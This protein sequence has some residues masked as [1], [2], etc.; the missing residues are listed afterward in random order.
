M[1]NRN[2]LVMLAMGAI[3]M[4][5]IGGNAHAVL[6]DDFNGGDVIVP[7]PNTGKTIIQKPYANAIGGWR[8]MQFVYRDARDSLAV[9]GGVLTH[10]EDSQGG[11]TGSKVIWHGPPSTNLIYPPVDLTDGGSS[12]RFRLDITAVEERSCLPT[13]EVSVF[14]EN[15]DQTNA[16]IIPDRPGPYDILFTDFKAL[17][18]VFAGFDAVLR[19]QLMISGCR[20]TSPTVV[21][22]IETVEPPQGN[23]APR[24]DANGPYTGK[25]EH[26]VNFDGSG[27]SDP[28]GTIV[29][30]DWDF[31]D[32]SSGSGANTTHVYEVGGV[33]HVTL[34]VTDDSNL[35]TSATTTAIIGAT[36][37]PPVADANG[38]YTGTRGVDV[39][40]DGSGSSDPDGTIMNYEWDF[41]DS[42]VGRGVNPSHTYTESNIYNVTLTVSDDTGEIDQTVTTATIAE[43]NQPP[44]VDLNGPYTGTVGEVITFDGSGSSDPD[45]TIVSYEWD[46]GDGNVGSGVSP[47]HSYAVDDFYH[48]TLTVTDDS[49]SSNSAT[50]LAGINSEPGECGAPLYDTSVDQAIF[51]WQDCATGDWVVRLSAGSGYTQYT[52]SIIGAPFSIT[53]EFRLEAGDILSVG[54]RAIVFDMRVISPWEDGFSFM[55][56]ADSGACFDMSAT[57]SSSVFV[58][59]S[60]TPATVPFNLDTLDPC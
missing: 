11:N 9:S 23:Q 35:P 42:L 47:S 41:G 2:L 38:P 50:T 32:G 6:I 39:V 16:E 26:G 52:G 13:L 53:G 58:G 45:G 31:G 37:E 48:V 43:G 57:R 18:G 44:V 60:R 22:S 17:T 59:P 46:F 7:D 54:W 4:C 36:S 5:L 20:D 33:Y 28:D 40:F 14:D 49:G 1:K 3:T 19:V 55:V 56:P 30:Y 8:E 27:S 15:G 10:T 12:D 51:L 25:A 24:A 21:N 34:T 29:S